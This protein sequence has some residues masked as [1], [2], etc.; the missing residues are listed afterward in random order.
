MNSRIKEIQRDVDLMNKTFNEDAE[1][2]EEPE[3]EEPEVEETE[4]EPELEPEPEPEEPEEPA[5][6]LEPE[7]EPE[8]SE[9]DERDQTIA[10]LRAKLAE[11]ESIKESATE[12]PATEA[13]LTFDDQNFLGE[14]DLDDVIS[15]PKAFNQLLN[16]L[17]QRA[18]TDTRKV[19]GEGILRSIPDIVKSN[20]VITNN[21][22]KTSEQVFADNK[23]LKP[24]RK[25]VAAVFEEVYAKN[26]DKTYDEVLKEVADESR[27]RLDLHKKAQPEKQSPPR[28][29][30]SKSRPGRPDNKPPL[31]GIENELEA[32]NKILGR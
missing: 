3:V 18:V 32:M 12:P 11:K 14:L 30:R 2:V 25:V 5:E 8:E 23:D 1:E 19:L 4:L 27:I 16:K 6:E 31:T 21:L 22:Q 26:P 29:P 17:Y 10:D 13:P 28:L 24:F 7:P 20:I 15:D 9:L